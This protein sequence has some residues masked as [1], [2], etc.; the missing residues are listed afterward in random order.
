M[1]GIFRQKSPGNII[2]LIILGILIKLPSFFHAKGALIKLGDGILYKGL[3]S[4]IST[5]TA[6]NFFIFSLLAFILNIVLAFML[7]HFINAHRLMVKSNFLAGM[8]Y[9]LVSSFLPSFNYFS[10]NLIASVFIFGAFINFFKSSNIKHDKNNIFNASL[11]I[12]IASLFFLPAFV[13]VIWGFIALAILR[14]FRLSEWIILVLGA[15]TPYYFFA[16]YLF[17]SG[18]FHIPE[19]FFE[20]S[21]FT[22]KATYSLWHAGALFLLL[23]PLL[24]GI[25]YMQANSGK[26]MLHIRKAW[27]LFLWYLVISMIVGLFNIENSSENM[28]LILIPIAAFHG[29]GYLNAEL[30]L[31]PKISFWVSIAFIV[32]SQLFSG[33]W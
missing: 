25:Y 17:L 22:S 13:F 16:A 29:Y 4:L 24:A 15:T 27:Y 18:N 32:A 33:M 3:I 5:V 28:I 8:S 1:T 6:N 23:A 12:G 31:Y 30:K 10:S 20:W 21:F 9:I 26:M 14:P 2:L 7:L 11:L 19:Y